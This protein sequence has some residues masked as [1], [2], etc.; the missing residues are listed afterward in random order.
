MHRDLVERR[1]WFSE[2]DYKEGLPL[3]PLAPGSL[4]VQ[5]GIF[6]GFVHYGVRSATLA[7]IAF[8]LPSFLMVL[9]IGLAYVRYGG[10]P[11][12]QAVFYGLGAA[13]WPESPQ[14]PRGLASAWLGPRRSRFESDSCPTGQDTGCLGIGT[15]KSGRTLGVS[16]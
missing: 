15:S 4:A 11:W 1:K 14:N 3:A 13:G 6:L 16:G 2:S 12:R 10:L 5:L 9:A 7:G 8:V